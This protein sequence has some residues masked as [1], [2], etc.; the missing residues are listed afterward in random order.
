MT[1]TRRGTPYI[2]V[3]WITGLLAGE[4]H[5]LWA[6]WYRA[7]FKYEKRADPTFNSAAW[8]AAHDRLV[9]ERQ[10]A[11]ESEG[12]EC[13]VEDQNALKQVGKTG[14][15]AGKPDL[16]ALGGVT[17]RVSD[18]KTGKPRGADQWQ[19]LV[20]LAMLKRLR[21]EIGRLS[22]EGVYGDGHITTILPE[23]LTPQR[24]EDIFALVRR[25][26][27]EA[28]PARVPSAR[29]CQYCDVADCPERYV[30]PAEHA[31]VASEF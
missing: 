2:W 19:V 18:A 15:L 20:Y 1:T 5:C 29:E 26:A 30:A 28:V 25:L 16:L 6:A 9:G 7:H 27:G 23:E 3:S 10:T 21:P 13:S 31:A 22:G 12:Y 17:P 14:V 4:K 24:E 11:L 8:A